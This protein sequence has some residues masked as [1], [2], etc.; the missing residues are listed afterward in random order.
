MKLV[1]ELLRRARVE[2]YSKDTGKEVYEMCLRWDKSRLSKIENEF[3]QCMEGDVLS[4]LLTERDAEAY[5]ATLTRGLLDL[6]GDNDV[7]RCQV[8]PNRGD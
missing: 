7:E 8:Q 5:E 1:R 2:T 6:L 4:F 3:L